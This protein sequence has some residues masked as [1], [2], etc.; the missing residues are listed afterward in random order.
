MGMR[1]WTLG[2]KA[3][4]GRGANRKQIKILREIRG[5]SKRAQAIECMKSEEVGGE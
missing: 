2:L 5:W 1:H 4:S 3:L